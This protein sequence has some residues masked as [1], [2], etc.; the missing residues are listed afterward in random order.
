MK[1]EIKLLKRMVKESKHLWTLFSDIKFSEMGGSSVDSDF[2]IEQGYIKREPHTKV[3][4]EGNI[5]E[6]RFDYIITTKG[7]LL[8]KDL[9]DRKWQLAGVLISGA[10]LIL[11]IIS[12]II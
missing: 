9:R 1:N 6:K 3:D 12:L 11:M 8:L 4:K 10:V 7:Y 2:L 5:T